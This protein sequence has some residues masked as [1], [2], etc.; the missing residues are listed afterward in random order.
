MNF[1]RTFFNAASVAWLLLVS[2]GASAD[3]PCCDE[4]HGFHRSG[5]LYAGMPIDLD[6]G[7]KR[8][9]RYGVVIAVDGASE[10]LDTCA[11]QGSLWIGGAKEPVA[12]HGVTKGDALAVL[13][14]DVSRIGSDTTGL[15]L[16]VLLST[17]PFDLQGHAFH[18]AMP[19]DI[20]AVQAADADLPANTTVETLVVGDQSVFTASA[21]H[22]L[23]G[24]ES[25]EC[26]TTAQ[27]VFVR[28]DGRMRRIGE[29]PGQPSGVA[30]ADEPYLIVPVNCGKQLGIWTIGDRLEQVGYFDNGYEYGGS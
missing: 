9:G 23:D 15:S 28:R 3:E 22:L 18:H 10:L 5:N 14:I 8:P 1:R 27:A 4:A 12:C 20:N 24:N 29:L 17:R 7:H 30:M 13:D 19:A 25:E 11:R 16:P 6:D 26:A 2:A 21:R